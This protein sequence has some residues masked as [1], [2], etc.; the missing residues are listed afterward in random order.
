MKNVFTSYFV[1]CKIQINHVVTNK[2]L[3]ID[4]RR[5]YGFG[6]DSW[7]LHITDCHII[8]HIFFTKIPH[9]HLKDA[10]SALYAYLDSKSIP[11]KSKVTN[12]FYY[13]VFELVKSFKPCYMT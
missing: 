11:Y 6:L 5:T 8:H 3:M 12:H 4:M 9:Y 2:L 7:M 13:D 10:T 1:Q